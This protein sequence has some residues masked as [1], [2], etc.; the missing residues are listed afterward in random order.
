MIALMND[1]R[2][3]LKGGELKGDRKVGDRKVTATKSGER[4]E[5][6]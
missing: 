6:K 1:G 3:E 4:R 5:Y 2:R